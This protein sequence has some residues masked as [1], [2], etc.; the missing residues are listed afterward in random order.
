[1]R[2]TKYPELKA[3][4]KQLAK[5]IRKWKRN[6]KL[7]KRIELGIDLWH[8]VSKVEQY[9]YEFRHKHIA[10]CMLRGRTYEQIELYCKVSPN[11]DYVDAV[12]EEHGPQTVCASA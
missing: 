5:D 2:Y 7:D 9:K 10:Y 4:L 6:R 12:M 8:A 3:E 11:F 1:M